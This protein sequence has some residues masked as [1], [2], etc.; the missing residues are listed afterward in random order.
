V[1]PSVQRRKVW[2]TP[3]TKV[4][5]SNAAKTRNPLKFA[6]C[7][8][9]ANGSQPLVGRRSPYYQNMWRMYCRLTRF[10]RLSIYA[11]VAKTWPDK[12][13]RWCR[14]GDF[15]WPPC[16]ADADI[17]F[18]AQR[19]RM[20]FFTNEDP[21]NCGRPI[22]QAIIFSSCGFCLLSSSSFFFFPRLFL[23]CFHT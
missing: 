19:G 11:L 7:P 14:D 21:F 5:C 15:L 20:T 3:T 12:F 17:I 16:V 8:K 10:F 4:P 18:V 23:P 2:L 22:G 6:A 9:L 1:A 13:V